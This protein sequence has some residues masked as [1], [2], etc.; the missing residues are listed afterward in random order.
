MLQR[1]TELLDGALP[2]APD[3]GPF[4]Q[5]INGDDTGAHR[6]PRTYDRQL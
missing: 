3:T 4:G 5:P 1:M 6:Y 2:P